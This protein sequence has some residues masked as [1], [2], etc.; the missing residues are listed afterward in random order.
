MIEETEQLEVS[1]SSED[2]SEY[3]IDSSTIFV[4][5]QMLVFQQQQLSDLSRVLVDL[6]EVSKLR[7][8]PPP[9]YLPL[10]NDLSERLENT[11]IQDRSTQELLSG[12]GNKFSKLENKLNK[13]DN[14]SSEIKQ[15]T[16]IQT[17]VVRQFISWRLPLQVFIGGLMFFNIVTMAS[18]IFTIKKNSS[19][20]EKLNVLIVQNEEIRIKLGKS[21]TR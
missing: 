7:S 2:Y 10:I 16:N 15:S 20:E 6:V 19:L 11:S 1:T 18:Q 14:E 13:L 9:N 3:S 17:N 8:S 21:R 5:Y 12:L 4:I